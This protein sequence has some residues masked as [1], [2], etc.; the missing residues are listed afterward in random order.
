[1]LSDFFEN[2]INNI[3]FFDA[4]VILIF[5]YCII[6]CFIKGFSLS[7]ISFMKWVLSTVVT[8]ILV[9]KFQPIVSDYVESEFINSI[10]LGIAIFVFTLFIIIIFSKAISRAVTWTGVGSI[11]KSFGLLFGVFKGYVVCVCIFSILNWFYP[12]K[13]WGISVEDT[14]SFNLIYK[15]SELLIEEFPS[16]EDF[17]DTKEKLEKI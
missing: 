10:G 15:G 16:S 12:Y 7:V 13:N 8:I 14:I 3:F 11:D 6:E 17:I 9:P 2:I 1:M 4:I 5:V